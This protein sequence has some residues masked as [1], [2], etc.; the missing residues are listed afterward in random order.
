MPGRRA[1]LG[2]GRCYMNE[3]GGPVSALLK[4]YKAEPE[5]LIVVHDE[6]DLPYGDM[7]VKFGG[8]DNGHNGLKSDPQARSAPVTTTGSG[9]GSV[10]RRARQETADFVLK[11]FSTHRAVAS[12]TCTSTG[13]RTRWSRC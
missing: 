2:R 8:G 7:R 9:S 11:P 12:S 3:S 13:R 5:Q 10:G 1:V 4:F 6:I